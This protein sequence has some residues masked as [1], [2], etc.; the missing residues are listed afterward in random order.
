MVLAG[1]ANAGRVEVIMRHA[2]SRA[3]SFPVK[4]WR[5]RGKVPN[6]NDLVTTMNKKI[7]GF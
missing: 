2:T 5:R 6:T 1:G 7:S 4:R 3:N